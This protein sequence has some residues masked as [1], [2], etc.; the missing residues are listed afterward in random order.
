MPKITYKESKGLVT[1][2]GKGVDLVTGMAAGNGVNIRHPVVSL[3]DA[4]KTVQ[5]SE[6]GTCFTLNRAAGVVVTL[7]AAEAGLYYEFY[8]ET[9]L[10]SNA[11]AVNAASS[12]DKYTGKMMMI[13]IATKNSH[14]DLNDSVA[15][16]GW[17]IP[18]ANDYQL[19]TNK[20]TTGGLAGSH[21]RFW[22][23]TDGLWSVDGTNVC[24]SGATIAI[25]FAGG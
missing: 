12:A 13:D 10:T 8:V 23:I 9:A 25:P 6:S 22:C 2:G 14:I 15:T 16:I 3:T 1:E 19:S 20:T 21:W 24:S 11:Y 5:V 17:S 4:T 18:H 7:P